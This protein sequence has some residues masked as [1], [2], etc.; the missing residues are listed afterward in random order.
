M[1]AR[2]T[3]YHEGPEASARQRIHNLRCKGSDL[4]T[5]EQTELETLISC[6]PDMS[7]PYSVVEMMARENELW[8]TAEKSIKESEERS[9]QEREQRRARK[10]AN[11]SKDQECL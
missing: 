1:K 10:R 9:R 5:A 2:V 8:D 3:A 6:Y 4:N 11:E 7:D